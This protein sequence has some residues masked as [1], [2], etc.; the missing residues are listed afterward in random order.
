M[1][2]MESIIKP[3]ELMKNEKIIKEQEYYEK[4]SVKLEIAK[5]EYEK[6]I[7]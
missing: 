3:N 1:R 4:N 7:A 6:K 5:T 2:K